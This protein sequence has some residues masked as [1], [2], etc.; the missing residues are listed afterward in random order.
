MYYW[1]WPAS[2]V[3]SHTYYWDGDQYCG[4]DY[5][6]GDLTADFSDPYD[7]ANMV[8][9]C[10]LG[11]SPD[12]SAA[13]AELNSEVG[14]AFNMDYSACGSGASVAR[15]LAVYP[16]FFK[17][18]PEIRKDDRINNTL[19]SWFALIQDEINAGRVIQ[20]RINM[21]SIVCDGWREQGSQYEYHMNYGW[22]GSSTAWYVLDNLYCYWISGDVCPANEEF[23]ITHIMPQAEPV[24]SCVG[25]V[26]DDSAGDGDG[27]AEA[28]ESGSLSVTIVNNGWDAENVMGELTTDDP[29]VN[30][31]ISTASFGALIPWGD[32]GSTE[33][34]F[35]FSVDPSCPDPHVAMFELTVTSTGGYTVVDTLHLFIGQTAGFADD[36][37]GGAGYW[38][39]APVLHTYNDQW[40]LETHSF[41]SGSYSWKA[42]GAGSDN[43]VDMHDGGLVTPPFLLPINAQLTFW[44]WIDAELDAEPG[45]AWDGGIVMISPG[46][47]SWTQITPNGGYPYSIVDNPASPFAAGTPCFSGTHDWTEV[48]FDLS[49]YSGVVQLMFRFGSDGYVTQEGWYIDDVAVTSMGCCLIRG[50]ADRNGMLDISDLTYYV[51]YMF[52]GGPI[53]V[54]EEE[55]DFNAD[56]VLDIS[57]LTYYTDYM[58][59][60]GPPPPICL[61]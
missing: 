30:V 48:A 9:S 20:Y 54:C 22:A 11:C 39:H 36:M 6:G 42:G 5:G 53:P 19:E 35:V 23:M 43:Y 47:G 7:W 44:Q 46:D 3:G 21:H 58:F 12:A 56:G 18:S 27:H 60:G 25:Q 29:N 31:T 50:D 52:A 37:D 51:D 57:D 17:Y 49:G 1:Q 24:I 38:T 13:L 16:T 10:D 2:G 34:D 59:N 28:G 8:D 55:G 26:L 15:A 61:F 41:H 45:W 33:T 4:G 14:I 32:E 40:H